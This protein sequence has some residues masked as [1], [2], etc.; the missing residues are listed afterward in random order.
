MS[1]ICLQNP[2]PSLT[3][4]AHTKSLQCV[5]FSGCCVGHA[6]IPMVVSSPDH[7]FLPCP[8]CAQR[9]SFKLGKTPGVSWMTFDL[10]ENAGPSNT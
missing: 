3:Q 9:Y 5:V 4:L 2:E 10:L 1:T 7:I 6:R 8:P